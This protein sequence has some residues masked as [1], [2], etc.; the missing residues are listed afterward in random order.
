MS[1]IVYNF[2]IPNDLKHSHDDWEPSHKDFHIFNDGRYA[3]VLLTYY[4]MKKTG[5][6]ARISSSLSFEQI[7]LTHVRTVSEMKVVP[8]CF[9]IT[10][11]ADWTTR[12][13]FRHLDVVQNQL[14]AG[15]SAVW[16]PHWP[17]AGLLPR[18]HDRAEVR[19]AGF[20]GRVDNETE[21]KRIGE[22]LRVNGIDFIVRGEETWNNFSDLDL[23]LSLRFMAPYRIRRKP[24]TKLIN[25]WLAGVPFVALD[26]PA[27]EQIGCNGQDY[28]GVRTPEEVVEAIIALRE[29][30]ELY[31][32]LVE[33]GRKKAVEYDWKATTQRWT[34]L[35]EGPLRERYE[36]WKRRPLF[37]AVRFRLLHAAWMFWKRSIK[38]FAHHVHHTRA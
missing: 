8:P 27:F 18:A 32:M 17:Q 1:D 35:L 11:L 25:A 2:V 3:W 26:E 37:E 33:N 9:L 7:N 6:K 13:P 16:I 23:S 34:E 14:Q 21:F 5:L 28:L 12:V 24:P 38:V 4:L 22:R 36:L 31:R 29:N 19:R 20:L 30:P 10:C 15:P